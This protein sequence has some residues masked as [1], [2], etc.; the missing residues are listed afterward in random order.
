L[1]KVHDVL[2]GPEAREVRITGVRGTGK[3][4]ILELEGV[5]SQSQAN[6]L[7]GLAVWIREDQLP[8]L[9]A[10]ELYVASVIQAEVRDE[11]GHRVGIVADVMETGE[12]DVLIVKRDDGEEELIPALRSVLAGWDGSRRVLTVRWPTGEPDEN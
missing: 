5:E 3:F 12:N 8:P 6:D 7:K 1:L 9:G 10:S 11:A 4:W 2:L